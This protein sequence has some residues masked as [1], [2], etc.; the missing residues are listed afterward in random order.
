MGLGFGDLG[1]FGAGAKDVF[2]GGVPAHEIYF[3]GSKVWPIFSP[4][5]IQNETLV[6]EP[7]PPLATGCYV[8]LI[9]GGGPGQDSIGSGSSSSGGRGGGGGA[10]VGRLFI[11][12]AALGP[13]FSMTR[14]AAWTYNASGF[15]LV[16]SPSRFASGGIV[17]EAQWGHRGSYSTNA[18][19][20]T[21]TGITT[22]LRGNGGRGGVGAAAG[23]GSGGRNGGNAENVTNGAASGGGGGSSVG[24]AAGFEGSPGYAGT[25]SGGEPGGLN[26][27]GGDGGDSDYNPQTG[28]HSG[29]GGG[30]GGYTAGG[31]AYSGGRRDPAQRFGGAGGSSLVLVEWV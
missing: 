31:S 14:G 4:F 10:R 29:G 5:N 6:N 16:S 19:I 9:G 3:Q 27:R 20:T 26:K 28:I 25:V 22:S 12:V 23:S 21:V 18:A 11:P 17:L 8:T 24:P 2:V 13:T 7:V 1:P 30:G 15:P